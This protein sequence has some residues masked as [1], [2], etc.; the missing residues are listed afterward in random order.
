MYS[1]NRVQLDLASKLA[2]VPSGKRVGICEQCAV[3][4][5]SSIQTMNKLTYSYES[6]RFLTYE[7]QYESNV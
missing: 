2:N 6:Q 5:R 7:I 1:T 4:L 3:I